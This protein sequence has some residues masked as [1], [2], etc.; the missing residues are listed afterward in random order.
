[1]KRI[2]RKLSLF[3]LLN[4]PIGVMA[5]PVTVDGLEWMQ[6]TDTVNFSWNDMASVCDVGTG[7]CTGSLGTTDLT[8]WT[9]ASILDVGQLFSALTPHPGGVGRFEEAGPYGHRRHYHCFN[10]LLP[11]HLQQRSSV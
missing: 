5:A 2:L 11:L 7:A 9:W 3:V 6:V 8:G 10:P 1:M 4:A